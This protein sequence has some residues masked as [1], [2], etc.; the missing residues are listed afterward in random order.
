M[1]SQETLKTMYNETLINDPN[2]LWNHFQTT[3]KYVADIHAPVQSRKVRKIKAPWLTDAIKK[4]HEL[5]RL[6]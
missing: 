5:P 6:S 4:K 2:V 1:W 3:F